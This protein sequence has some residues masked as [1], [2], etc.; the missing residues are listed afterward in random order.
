MIDGELDA[1][2]LAQVLEAM[3]S[4]KQLRSL[5]GRYCQ[6]QAGLHDEL[7][8]DI[9]ERV[10]ARLE[11]EPTVIAPGAIRSGINVQTRKIAAGVAIAASVAAV[12][13]FGLRWAGHE[14]AAPQLVA[15]APEQADYIRASGTKW[16]A[17]DPGLENDLN[18][19]LV[20][21]GGY[22][23]TSGMN[24]LIPF[25]KVAGYDGGNN[26]R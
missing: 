12:S 9:A 26:Q 3:R 8:S 17:S 15:V 23:G 21:H 22:S 11:T 25:V 19:Y 14:S 18:T 7:G 1:A 24:G 13:V 10:R 2:E 16:T 5:Y 6:A 20:E 4:D